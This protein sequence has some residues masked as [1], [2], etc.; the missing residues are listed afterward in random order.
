[1]HFSTFLSLLQFSDYVIGPIYFFFFIRTFK[2]LFLYYKAYRPLEF[3]QY[4][5]KSKIERPCNMF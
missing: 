2:K 4:F 5:K 1:M 3:L